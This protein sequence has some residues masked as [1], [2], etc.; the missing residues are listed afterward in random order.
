[1][2]EPQVETEM[3]EDVMEIVS[4]KVSAGRMEGLRERGFAIGRGTGNL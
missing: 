1:M 2:V 4:S 3:N